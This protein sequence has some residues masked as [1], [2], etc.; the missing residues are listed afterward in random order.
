MASNKS[1]GT[2]DC[3]IDIFKHYD[4]GYYTLEDMIDFLNNKNC[5]FI[6]DDIYIFKGN[7]EYL[8]EK[9]MEY[10]KLSIKNKDVNIINIL[11]N[12]IDECK[13]TNIKDL[14]LEECKKR[15]DAINNDSNEN[16]IKNRF[17][18]HLIKN[19][20]LNTNY[21]L[22]GNKCKFSY[23]EKESLFIENLY[24]C[25]YKKSFFNSNHDTV[26]IYKIKIKLME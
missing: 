19:N 1:I 22:S 10:D 4:Y 20:F 16:K 7:K 9:I 15:I 2:C 25:E 13:I 14:L 17:N 23:F 26:K 24:L 6:V 11:E 3:L 18:E 5:N 21:F 8:K 12:I